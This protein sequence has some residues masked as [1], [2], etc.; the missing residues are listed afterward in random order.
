MT[1]PNNNLDL[2]ETNELS[3]NA[4]GGT[5]Q[6]LQRLY[7]GKIPREL[8]QE[9]Q[10]IPTRLRE[11]KEDKYRF[12]YCHDLPQDPEVQHLANGGW[13]KFTRLIFVS[14]W[15][16]QQ[17]MAQ[18]EIPWSRCVVMLNAI[19][20]IPRVY[21]NEE[22]VNDTIRLI[23]HTTPHR[24][25]NILLPVF[26]KLCETHKNIHLD[27]YSSFGLYG[28]KERDEQF[29]ALFDYANEHKHITNHGAVSSEEVRSALGSAHIFAYPSVWAETS[30]LCLME[31]MSAG[32]NC[33][34][35]NYGAL[36][37]TAANWTS[38]Y[39]WHENPNDHARM[40][41]VMLDNAI[42]SVSNENMQSRLA[43]QKVYTDAFYNWENRAMQWKALMQSIVDAKEDRSFLEE[44]FV[45]A[46]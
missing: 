26:D 30:C 1:T 45:Y 39:H 37:E 41:Y 27:V 12:Y 6:Q 11:I 43:S 16:A 34:H 15:Q 14:N 20:P 36:Y 42:K 35:P 5:E 28:W 22:H 19:M 38:M 24:G 31:A 9:F 18:F 8:I 4:N 21:L 29:Q 46:A 7:D 23:Y 33:V 40:H 32:L 25:L 17:F 3:K 13:R 10:I 2:L 44:E